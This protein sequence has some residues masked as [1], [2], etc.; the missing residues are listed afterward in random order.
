MH[1]ISMYIYWPGP[2]IPLVLWPLSS[3][4]VDTGQIRSPC[5]ATLQIA[6]TAKAAVYKDDPPNQLVNICSLP[7]K[8]DCQK[9]V[10]SQ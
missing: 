7:V 8:N 3:T 2:G 6:D 10:L 4:P 9:P 5:P 1:L